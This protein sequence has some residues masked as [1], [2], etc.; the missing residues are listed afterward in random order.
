MSFPRDS[1]ARFGSISAALESAGVSAPYQIQ[2]V[3]GGDINQAFRY[4]GSNG[5]SVFV[6]QHPDADPEH[7]LAEAEGL[8]ALGLAAEAVSAESGQPTFRVPEVL[9]LGQ[10]AGALQFLIL[11]YLAPQQPTTESWV[12][13]GSALASLHSL[14]PPPDRP[15]YGFPRDNRIGSSIQR[16]GWSDSWVEFFA[17]KRLAFQIELAARSG[18]LDQR[19]TRSAFDLCGSLGDFL[20]TSPP[21]ALLHG[22]LWRGNLMFSAS[23]P[24]FID[25]AAYWGHGEADLA[26]TELFGGFP[27]HFYRAYHQQVPEEQGSQKRIA[28][29][30]FYHL[31]NHLNLFGASYLSSVRAILSELGFR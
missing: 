20:P 21:P 4:T 26:M 24:V 23:L 29:Y 8:G 19:T 9:A 30:K 11:E 14:P 17:D 28:I 22:D 5:K 15:A 13:A 7:F 12:L 16:N 6:K 27:N 2:R 25:P 18:G 1:L 31:L 3:A 10:E